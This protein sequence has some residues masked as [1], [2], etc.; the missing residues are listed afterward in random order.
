MVP[1]FQRSIAFREHKFG[2]HHYLIPSDLIYLA[3]ALG[4][5]G[6]SFDERLSLLNRAVAIRELSLG[7]DKDKDGGRLGRALEKCAEC[8]DEAGRLVEAE[9]RWAACAAAYTEVRWRFRPTMDFIAKRSGLVFVLSLAR[10]EASRSSVNY[11]APPAFVLARG[12]G[13][14]TSSR[15]GPQLAWVQ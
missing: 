12:L 10:F 9:S 4:Q 11:C 2:L 15:S 7:R 1:L 8:Y 6:R 14:P 5:M 3:D 13:L